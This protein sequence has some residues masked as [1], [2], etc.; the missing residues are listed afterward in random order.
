VLEVVVFS[1]IAVFLRQILRSVVGDDFV[2]DAVPT[3]DGFGFGYDGP[4]FSVA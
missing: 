1:E 3:E 2:G 4:S